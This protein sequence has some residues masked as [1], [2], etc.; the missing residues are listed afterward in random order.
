METG[1]EPRGITILLVLDREITW[2][3]KLFNN[4]YFMS[5]PLFALGTALK[6]IFNN[7]PN[8]K[9]SKG[10]LYLVFKNI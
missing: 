4:I 9:K 5:S 7:Q 2:I 8:K 10:K 6:W 3:F 1:E